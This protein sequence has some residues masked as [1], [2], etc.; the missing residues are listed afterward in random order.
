MLSSICSSKKKDDVAYEDLCFAV[1]TP[2]DPII[3]TVFSL[4]LHMDVPAGLV[5]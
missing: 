5:S 2:I 4:G 1:A 3:R